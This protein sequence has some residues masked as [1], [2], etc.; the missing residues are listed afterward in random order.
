VQ[1]VAT[2]GSEINMAHQYPSSDIGRIASL[3]L[4][5]NR[6]ARAVTGC[7]RITPLS[8]LMAEGATHPAEAIVRSREACFYSGILTCAA[9]LPASTHHR[10]TLT[11]DIIRCLTQCTASRYGFSEVENICQPSPSGHNPGN[12][13]I[14]LRAEAEL[15]VRNWCMLD[16]ECI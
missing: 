10:A 14:A 13:I 11:K 3:Q 5:L 16:T 2:Y 9:L 8:F 15:T 4:I 6:Q 7:L 1:S 12:I